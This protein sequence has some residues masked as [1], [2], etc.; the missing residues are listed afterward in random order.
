MVFSGYLMLNGICLLSFFK[1]SKKNLHVLE[2]LTYW[3]VSSLLVQNY[4]ALNSMNFKTFIIPD[5]ITLEI[6]HFLNRT[7]LIPCMFL[8]F[9]N[10]YI[11]ITTFE[12]KLIFII[13][14]VFILVGM[15]W[16]QDWSGVFKHNHWRLWWS[17]TAW[18]ISVLILIGFTKFFH[19]KWFERMYSL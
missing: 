2:I 6:A 12:K 8:W 3:M 1:Y 14:F 7:L 10:S 15:E 19:R 16:F 13:G 4:S 5:V 11:V 17:Y 9:I 18:L